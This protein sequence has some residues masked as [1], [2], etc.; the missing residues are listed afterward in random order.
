MT[1]MRKLLWLLFSVIC[2]ISVLFLPKYKINNLRYLVQKSVRSWAF[3]EEDGALPS[4]P[5]RYQSGGGGYLC[6]PMTRS[7]SFGDEKK[8]RRTKAASESAA[9]DFLYVWTV[10]NVDSKTIKH[11]SSKVDLSATVSN[12]LPVR[13]H[14]RNIRGDM[15]LNRKYCSSFIVL[16][17]DGG[18]SLLD[19]ESGAFEKNVGTVACDSVLDSSCNDNSLL[20][21]YRKLNGGKKK[22]VQIWVSQYRLNEYPSLDA[23][24]C[25]QLDLGDNTADS[26]VDVAC[27]GNSVVVMFENG[28]FLVYNVCEGKSELSPSLERH[29]K[30][31]ASGKQGK[32]RAAAGATSSSGTRSVFIDPH[33][34]AFIIEDSGKTKTRVV[35][36]DLLYGSVLLATCVE[37]EHDT[38]QSVREV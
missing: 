15:S 22:Q 37:R 24:V 3:Q 2:V 19:G 1:C 6:V 26:V 10:E 21:V 32:K 29:L 12:V 33:S 36:I 4:G 38:G 35:C 17:S 9:S 30:T 5:A 28:S 11:I 13:C 34:R 27:R 23:C 7:S 31:N 16:S 20:V 14:Y 18:V 8:S 25:C